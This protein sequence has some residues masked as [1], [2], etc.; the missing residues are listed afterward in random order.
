MN[1]KLYHHHR[2]SA[3]FRVR[4]ALNLKNLEYESIFVDLLKGEHRKEEFQLRSPERLVPVLEIDGVSLSQSLAII[5]FV[6]EAFPEPAL[7]PKDIR[8]RARVRSFALAIAC[9][10]HPLNNLRV[11]QYLTGCI[12]LPSSTKDQW[13]R[14]WIQEGLEVLEG[15]VDGRGDYCFGTQP[16]LADVLL[17]PQLAN[18][19]R[20]NCDLVPY[21]RLLRIEE[22]CMKLKAFQK[23][24]PDNQVVTT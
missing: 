19:R 16:T 8:Q 1:L 3:S 20:A 9:D 7:L 18:A 2:S 10:I 12:G 6:E 14:H 22:A 4:I 15:V 24:A 21:P 11:L 23:A 5:D 17:V 13:Y